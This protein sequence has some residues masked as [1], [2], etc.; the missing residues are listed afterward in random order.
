MEYKI[1]FAPLAKFELLEALEYYQNI[2]ESLKIRIYE[3]FTQA[4]TKIERNPYLF[5]LIY[6]DKR[7]CILKKFPYSIFFRI[8]NETIQIISFFHQKRNPKDW[9]L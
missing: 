9:K 4:I 2:S 7:H 3:E 6:K 1:E 5:Q 8:N